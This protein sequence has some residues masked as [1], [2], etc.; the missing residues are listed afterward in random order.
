MRTSASFRIIVR[1]SCAISCSASLKTVVFIT[2]NNT[3]NNN[4]I[5]I[6]ADPD[7]AGSKPFLPDPDDLTETKNKS[8]KLNKYFLKNYIF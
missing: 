6:V 1:S 2:V 5:T 8:N 3:K 7:P 4:A